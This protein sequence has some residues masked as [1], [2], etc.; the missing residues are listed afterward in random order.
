MIA[1]LLHAGPGHAFLLQ[2][3]PVVVLPCMLLNQQCAC[4]PTYKR[5]SN[6]CSETGKRIKLPQQFILAERRQ[7]AFACSTPALPQTCVF[8][9]QRVFPEAQAR[10]AQVPPDC[11]ESLACRERDGCK[12][13]VACWS[14]TLEHL[15]VDIEVLPGCC[16]AGCCRDTNHALPR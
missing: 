3:C 4:S 9:Q 2:Q 12:R 6:E 1:A 11:M 5:A 13:C 15:Q 16:E 10:M 7:H 14:Q 8:G